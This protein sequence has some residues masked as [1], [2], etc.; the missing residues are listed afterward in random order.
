MKLGY[1]K[2]LFSPNYNR[3]DEVVLFK[4]HNFKLLLKSSNP[5]HNCEYYRFS[6]VPMPVWA[7]VQ[8]KDR[9]AATPTL[10]VWQGTSV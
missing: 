4:F 7:N 10:R 6:Q 9:T 1:E 2:V 8:A 3:A 5:L